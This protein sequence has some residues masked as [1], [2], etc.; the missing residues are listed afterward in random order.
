MLAELAK[1][2]DRI[3]EGEGRGLV[4]E[5]GESPSNRSDTRERPDQANR[6]QNRGTGKPAEGRRLSDQSSSLMTRIRTA[7]SDNDLA[8]ATRLIQTGTA[9]AKSGER[10]AWTLLQAELDCALGHHAE[11]G[12]AAMRIVI[13]HP[14][15][16]EVGNALYWAARAYEGIGRSSKALSLLQECLSDR[17]TDAT[18]RRQAES[19]LKDLRATTQRA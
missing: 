9:S 2:R 17:R 15:S 6:D 1:L 10:H 8:L 3:R 11:A 4:R 14:Q 19:R 12:L 16:P 13:Q 5:K 18:I 7:I